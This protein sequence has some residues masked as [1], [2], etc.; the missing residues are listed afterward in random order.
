LSEIPSGALKSAS[1]RTAS[2]PAV[3]FSG[4]GGKGL[5]GV[6][7]PLPADPGCG[8]P[9][10]GSCRPVAAPWGAVTVFPVITPLK[11]EP[12]AAWRL[13]GGGASGPCRLADDAGGLREVEADGE[14]PEEA[15]AP[16]L[17]SEAALGR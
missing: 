7:L 16:A 6:T 14:A 17:F 9:K 10:I 12:A 4:G 1:V 5:P 13:P 8:V 11:G 3:G 15:G 2:E